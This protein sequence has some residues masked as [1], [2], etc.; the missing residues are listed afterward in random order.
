MTTMTS[1][2]M[3]LDADGRRLLTVRGAAD[4][5]S[6]SRG[7]VYNLLDEGELRSIHI[8]R[9]RRIPLAELRRFVDERAGSC[10]AGSFETA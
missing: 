4:F 10:G 3:G 7:A 8:G 1:E 9:S 6:L 5:L 2:L